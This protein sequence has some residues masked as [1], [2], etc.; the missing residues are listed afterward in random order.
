MGNFVVKNQTSNVQFE[1]SN[2]T[3]IIQGQY[4]KNVSTS[5]LQSY[6]G[7]F[8]RKTEQG[9]MGEYFGNFNGYLR[10]GSAEVKYSM[11]EMSRTDASAAWDAIDEIEPYVIGEDG[12]GEQ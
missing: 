2:D 11:S 7:S 4:A 6:S 1:Y 8:Y 10:D 3:L 12:N 9:Q 5:V